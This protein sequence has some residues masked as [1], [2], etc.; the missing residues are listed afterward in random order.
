MA[1][2]PGGLKLN[3]DTSELLYFVKRLERVEKVT[4]P[5]LAVGLN[6][7]GDSLT[8]VLSISL[9]RTT[10][11][12]LEEVRGLLRIKRANRSDLAYEI[13]IDHDLL[14][15]GGRKL[16]GG[17]ESTDFG[18]L[19]P[20][21]LVIWVSKDD[22]LVC[23]DCVEMAAAGPMPASVAAARHP[24]HPHCRCI[25]MPYVQKGKR[26]PLTMTTVT[27]TSMTRRRGTASIDTDL[28]LRQ[29]AQTIMD[30]TSNAIRI[31]LS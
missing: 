4:K 8:S 20:N 19:D 29:L 23:M 21:R 14:E 18:K 6:E 17:R 26:L 15:E 2:N 9:T 28:T 7:V 31:E 12:S 3:I 16:E 27:G 5:V 22:E 10:G 1:G 24:R 30:K 11:L 25:L 13:R